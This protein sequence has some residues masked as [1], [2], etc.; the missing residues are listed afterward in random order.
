MQV[1]D[2]E[3]VELPGRQ[4]TMSIQPAKAYEDASV[5]K[6]SASI[7]PAMAYKDESVFPPGPLYR[8]INYGSSD[9][10]LVL[11]PHQSPHGTMCII[12]KLR[13]AQTKA[14]KMQTIEKVIR[15]RTLWVPAKVPV[16]QSVHTH[17]FLGSPGLASQ[18][19]STFGCQPI[20]D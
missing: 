3:E 10:L 2:A 17:Q 1:V 16:G 11:V 13:K 8:W 7:Q 5:M 6:E 20:L 18:P 4:L 9:S 14:I 12:R 15:L 19:C